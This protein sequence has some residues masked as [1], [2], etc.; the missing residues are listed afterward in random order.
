MQPMHWLVEKQ[1]IFTSEKNGPHWRHLNDTLAIVLDFQDDHPK[2]RLIY[3]S[4]LT[5]AWHQRMR[6]ASLNTSLQSFDGPIIVEEKRPS[7]RM[8]VPETG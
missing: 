8:I 3:T 4:K 2:N 1:L 5:S 6:F 7:F